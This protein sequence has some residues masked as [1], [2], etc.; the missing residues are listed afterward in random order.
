MLAKGNR[1]RS[2]DFKEA[3]AARGFN[4]PHFL[5]RI[6]RNETDTEAKIAVVVSV[7][8]ARTAVQRNLLRRRIYEILRSALP[9]LRGR[10]AVIT[11]KQGA[12]A[13]SFQE[14]EYELSALLEKGEARR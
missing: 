6:Q 2:A 10:S 1:L 4:S 9:S 8:V 12:P 11:A 7:R 14:L 5:F 13:L 3:R